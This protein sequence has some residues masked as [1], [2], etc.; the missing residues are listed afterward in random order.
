MALN[1]TT[2][3]LV[4]LIMPLIIIQLVILLLIPFKH[5]V[6]DQLN[7]ICNTETYFPWQHDIQHNGVIISYYNDIV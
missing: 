2:F 4:S 3:I 1:A 5:H 7:T 6:K